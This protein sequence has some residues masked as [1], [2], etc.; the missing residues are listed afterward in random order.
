MHH[1][2]CWYCGWTTSRGWV[3]WS[4][5]SRASVAR[6]WH[7]DISDGMATKQFLITWIL[8]LNIIQSSN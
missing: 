6:Q 5:R 8:Y 3:E 7:N 2:F 1:W 4:L